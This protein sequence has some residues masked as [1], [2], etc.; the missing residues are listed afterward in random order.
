MIRSRCDISEAGSARVSFVLW[1]SDIIKRSVV[2]CD[3]RKYMPAR[4]DAYTA[5]VLPCMHHRDFR[6]GIQCQVKPN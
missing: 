2:A 3:N 5:Y 6:H 1:I 4:C